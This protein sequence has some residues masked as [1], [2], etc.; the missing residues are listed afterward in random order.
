MGEQPCLDQREPGVSPGEALMIDS[1]AKS[2]ELFCVD[3]E[4]NPLDAFPD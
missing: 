3:L 1:L 4:L 2:G